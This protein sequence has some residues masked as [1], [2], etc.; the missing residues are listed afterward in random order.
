MNRTFLELIRGQ[1]LMPAR[2]GMEYLPRVQKFLEGEEVDLPAARLQLTAMLSSGSQKT[3]TITA[4]TWEEEP[5]HLF[6]DLEE[7]AVMVIP[8][9]GVITK[10]DV[11]GWYGALTFAK[12]IR[13]AAD[14]KHVKSLVLNLDTPGGTADGSYDFAEA[15]A[16]ASSKKPVVSYINGL[17]CSAGY[18]VAAR[19]SLIVAKPGS[20]LGS[21]GTMLSF[22]DDSARLAMQGYRLITINADGSPDKN[23]DSEAAIKGDFAP[24]R[25]SLLNPMNDL[26]LQEMKAARNL[27]DEVLTGKIFD[28]IKS[29]SN[30][31]IDVIGNMEVALKAATENLHPTTNATLVKA[32]EGSQNFSDKPKYDM[33]L[34]KLGASILAFLGLS[35]Q[36]EQLSE[37]QVVKLEGLAGQNL[38]LQQDLETAQRLAGEAENNLNATTAQYQSATATISSLEESIAQKDATITDLT[39]ERDA[40]AA[41][42]EELGAQ[43][44]ALGTT[45]KS[46]KDDITPVVKFEL[47]PEAQAVIDRHFP[48]NKS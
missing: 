45:A 14:H 39:S 10:Y 22:Y 43:P 42:V 7:D 30:G 20:V 2:Y 37:E 15:V 23:A 36:P 21:I 13:S 44:G 32:A 33:K 46:K 4:D 11:C 3:F 18:R 19:S 28:P 41:K 9:E 25:E 47:D 12:V 48:Q 5:D 40:L 34:P 6:D 1:W 35:E 24:I 16:Y 29:L 38:R 27:P 31:L 26:F 17:T 8:V